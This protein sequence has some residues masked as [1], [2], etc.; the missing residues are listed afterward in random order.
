[1]LIHIPHTHKTT[2]CKREERERACLYTNSLGIMQ[3]LLATLVLLLLALFAVSTLAKFEPNTALAPLH[4]AVDE[5]NRIEGEYIIVFREDMPAAQFDT[6]VATLKKSL[7]SVGGSQVLNVHS[8]GSS[9]RAVYARLT[10]EALN[11][12]RS[13]PFVSFVEEHQLVHLD[14]SCTVQQDVIWN[15]ARIDTHDIDLIDDDY[16]YGHNGQGVDVYIIDTGVLTTHVEFK[17]KAEWGYNS[18]DTIDRDCNGHGTHVAGTVAGELYGVAKGA[19]IIAVKVLGCSGSGTYEGVIDGIEWTAQEAAKRGRP[20]V[21][22]MSLG[23]GKS[24]AVNAAVA[25]AVQAGV[26]FAVAAGNENTDACTRSPASELSAIT[27]AATTIGT[28]PG[29]S[30]VDVRATFSN[31][32]TC[33]DIAAPGQLVKAAW[34][35]TAGYPP[36]TAVNTIS[37]TSM[38]SPH[39]AGVAA[40]VLSRHPTFTPAQ[41][42]AALFADATN[43]IINL[44][45]SGRAAC[46]ATPNRLLYTNC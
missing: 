10:P 18:A 42:E 23:G 46:E 39:V 30:S 17:G 5:V 43:G 44:A 19:H 6:Q 33:V 13:M 27:V 26:T 9:F 20:S 3:K 21:A 37:G 40:I 31:F 38:A 28:G 32:G 36:N 41:V 14:Q 35:D 16:S 45:C 4:T 29:G 24:V 22:N 12:V 2:G 15:L 1:M 25:A 8:I 7:S 34:I 11:D